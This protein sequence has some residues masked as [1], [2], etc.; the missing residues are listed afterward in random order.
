MNGGTAL[1]AEAPPV[2]IARTIIS[3]EFMF[4]RNRL[5]PLLQLRIY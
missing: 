5:R 1:A 3:I 2:I 4:A